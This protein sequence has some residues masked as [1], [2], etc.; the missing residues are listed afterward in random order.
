MENELTLGNSVAIPC[1]DFIVNG[2]AVVIR[3]DYIGDPYFMAA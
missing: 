2:M 1:V 3:D